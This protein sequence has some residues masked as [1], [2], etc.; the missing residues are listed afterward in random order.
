MEKN[1][2]LIKETKTKEKL[3]LTFDLFKKSW[4]FYRQ[5]FL[6]FVEMY[7]WGLLGAVPLLIIALIFLGVYALGFNNIVIMALFIILLL[8]ALL[9]SLYYGIRAHIGIILLIKNKDSK[10]RAAFL[11]TK[12]FFSSYVIVSIVSG[13]FL[14]LLTL[15]LVIPGVIF[16]VY[17]AFATMLVVVEG[18]KSTM[19]A[20]SRS[21]ALVKGHWW[22]V[23]GRLLFISFIYSLVIYILMIPASSS[24]DSETKVQTFKY[25]SQE[26]GDVYVVFINIISAI[27]SPLLL[28]YTYFLYKDLSAKKK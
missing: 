7:L 13:V 4:Q 3:V 12:K 14:M 2:E 5:R 15:L 8:L 17:W 10:A 27:L 9:W 18:I 21:K 20:L 11:E 1:H 25:L 23:A 6:S 16:Y 19:P 22:P 24:V 26:V 28:A